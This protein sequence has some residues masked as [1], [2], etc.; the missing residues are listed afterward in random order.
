LTLR[1]VLSDATGESEGLGLH[2]RK[3]AVE[4]VQFHPESVPTDA[5]KKLVQNFL[6]MINN[7]A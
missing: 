5:G 2:H 1:T 7:Q 3:C 4:G 6:S